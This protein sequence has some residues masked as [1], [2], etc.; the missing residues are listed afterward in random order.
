[1]TRQIEKIQI[2]IIKNKKDT[3]LI[4]DNNLYEKAKD[5]NSPKLFYIFYG[6]KT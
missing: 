4:R 1:M 2:I 3:I 6:K 5:L